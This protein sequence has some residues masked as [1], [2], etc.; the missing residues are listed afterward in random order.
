MSRTT[1]TP[2]TPIDRRTS[3]SVGGPRDR[4]R[5]DPRRLSVEPRR[6]RRRPT[7]PSVRHAGGDDAG[8]FRL[9][10]GGQTL[11]RRS[12]P[13]ERSGS[14][15]SHHPARWSPG[16]PSWPPTNTR[17]LG[18]PARRHRPRRGGRD[19]GARILA[20]A[21]G[22]SEPSPIAYRG[23]AR[24]TRRHRSVEIADGSGGVPCDPGSI[25][26]PEGWGH[27]RGGARRAPSEHSPRERRR[28][29]RAHRAA[30]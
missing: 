30:Q 15:A 22:G 12:S 20:E 5:A 14:M 7:K 27:R 29:H 25:C 28:P 24:L 8:R 23:D 26:S 16:R 19:V 1:A 3:T 10:P 17:S 18:D 6:T 13:R 21:I 2:S 11:T 9:L 4:G